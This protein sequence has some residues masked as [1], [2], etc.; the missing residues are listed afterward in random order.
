MI[1]QPGIARSN[2]KVQVAN[3]NPPLLEP[4]VGRSQLPL[5]TRHMHAVLEFSIANDP[6]GSRTLQSTTRNS[7]SAI[8]FHPSSLS[9][10]PSPLLLHPS[11][12][13]NTSTTFGSKCV[14]E[15]DQICSRTFSSGQ[16]FRYGRSERRASH[17]STTAKM[18]AASGI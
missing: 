4:A 1:V 5:A 6:F 12:F 18:R 14:P 10:H 15:S 13:K 8:F 9:L 7:H 17:T 16:P 2:P 11:I 3:L